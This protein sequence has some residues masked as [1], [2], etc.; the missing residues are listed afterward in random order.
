LSAAASPPSP[1]SPPSSLTTSPAMQSA[2]DLTPALASAARSSC[3]TFSEHA[4]ISTALRSQKLCRVPIT[5]VNELE[6][7]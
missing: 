5:A 3:V 4:R 6:P 2:A 7:A 1:P